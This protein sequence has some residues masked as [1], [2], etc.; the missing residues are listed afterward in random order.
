M[1]VEGTIRVLKNV[2][3]KLMINPGGTILDRMVQ[4]VAYTDDMMLIAQTAREL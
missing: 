3:K 1:E 4:C 2:I